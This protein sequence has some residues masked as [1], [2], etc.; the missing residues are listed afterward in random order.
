MH[1]VLP[2]LSRDLLIVTDECIRDGGED[3]PKLTWVVDARDENNLVPISTL[4][5]PPVEEF[6]NRGGRY[7]SHNL[8]ENRPG[9]SYRSDTIV[10]ATFFNGGVRAF[11]TSNPFQPTEIAHFVPENPEGSRAGACQIN[12]VY[13]DENRI[14]YCVD[15]STGGLY[16]LEME[17]EI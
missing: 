4:P 11:D 8:H 15:R 1:T 6:R 3:W 10:F 14:C 5:I 2:L 7:G 9:P 13:V 17:V 12:D 16:I